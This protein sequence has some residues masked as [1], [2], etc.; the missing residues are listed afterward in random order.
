MK[1]LRKQKKKLHTTIAPSPSERQRRETAR[2]LPRVSYPA[3]DRKIRRLGVPPE[4]LCWKCDA[5]VFPFQSTKEVPPLRRML[6]QKQ[7]LRSL[8]M[9]L[10]VPSPGYNLFLCG[11]N[12]TESLAVIEEFI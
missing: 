11:L 7:A 1:P 12:G 3:M 5:S 10:S 6:G 9:G 4:E 8:K 2:E